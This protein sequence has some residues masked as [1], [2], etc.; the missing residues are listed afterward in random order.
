[1]TVLGEHLVRHPIDVFDVAQIAGMHERGAAR[2]LDLG[3]DLLQ[4]LAGARDEQHVPA[5]VGDLQRR[6]APDPGRR[7]GYEHD[8]AT[9]CGVQPRGAAHAPYEPQGLVGHLLADHLAGAPDHPGAPPDR[10]GERAVAEQVGV[11]VALPVVPQLVRIRF[12]RRDADVG[13]LQRPLRL[14]RVEARRIVDVRQHRARNPE[15]GQ[16]AVGDQVEARNRRERGAR[17]RGHRVERAGRDPTRGLR[18]VGRACKDVDHLARAPRVGVGEAERLAVAIVEV[19]DVIHRLDD[20][21]D[22][23]EVDLPPLE[24]RSAESTGAPCCAVAGSA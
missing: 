22:R 7:A 2:R 1:M 17:E 19:G 3:L 11:E 9:D 21:V 18:R 4:L 15:L 10:T 5:G 16:D 13:A 20:E 14:A 12:E 23:D 8:P 6:G 24:R